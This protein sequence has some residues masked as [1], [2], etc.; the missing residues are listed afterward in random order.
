[1]NFDKKDEYRKLIESCEKDGNEVLKNHF[2]NDLKIKN[3]Q[4]VSTAEHKE[5]ITKDGNKINVYE[6]SGQPFTMLVHAVVDNRM[7]INN[8]YVSQIVN[9]PEDW[10]KIN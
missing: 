6:L 4:I 10:D 5:I 8:S 7:S 2:V 3:Q 9:N 1:M